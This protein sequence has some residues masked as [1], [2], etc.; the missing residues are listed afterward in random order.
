MSVRALAASPVETDVNPLADLSPRGSS[1]GNEPN[2]K[3]S[4]MS[5]PFISSNGVAEALAA[6]MAFDP[7]SETALGNY[8]NESWCRTFCTLS[9]RVFPIVPIVL[10]MVCTASWC[11]LFAYFTLVT[12]IDVSELQDSIGVPP[13]ALSVLGSTVGFVL[14]VRINAANSKWWE[15]R[16]HFGAAVTTCVDTT[17]LFCAACKAP[18]GTVQHFV[19]THCLA[20]V[21]TLKNALRTKETDDKADRRELAPFMDKA[22]YDFLMDATPVYRP[23]LVLQLLRTAVSRAAADRTLPEL[24]AQ[25]LLNNL[26]ELTGSY[27]ACMKVKKTPIPVT[28]LV[29]PSSR[30]QALDHCPESTM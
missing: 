20:F 28:Y 22:E 21:V 13:S 25:S 10:V 1:D 24:T 29:C 4:H 6:K 30:I 2:G 8:N 15:G 23:L 18:D 19:G 26:T 12:G 5:D 27:Y 7:K 3:S 9:G 16:G 11:T 17:A 14:C